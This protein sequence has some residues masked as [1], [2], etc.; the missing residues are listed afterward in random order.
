VD[1]E[2]TGCDRNDQGTVDT[3]AM[4]LDQPAD[5]EWADDEDVR[6]AIRTLLA[7]SGVESVEELRI[8]AQSSS[9]SSE[10]ARTAWLVI[11][12]LAK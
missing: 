6:E 1:H 9:F 8:Q 4:T 10:R 11:A 3:M 2:T 7:K 5:V 12:A